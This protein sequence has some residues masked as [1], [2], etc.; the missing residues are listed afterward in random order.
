[1]TRRRFIADEVSEN[2]AVLT[3]GHA[4]HVARVLRVQVGQEFDISVGDAVRQ[5]TITSIRDDR[6]EFALGL[7][8]QV[9]KHAQ[10]T[11][12]LSIFKFDRME[13][14]IEKCTEIGVARIVPLVARRTDARLAAAAVKRRERWERIARQASEQSRRIAP[15]EISPPAKLEQLEASAGVLT[16][17]QGA[18]RI[19][20]G[21]SESH[22]MLRDV[23]ETHLASMQDGITLAIGPEGGWTSDERQCFQTSGWTQASLGNTILRSETAAVVASA[24]AMDGMR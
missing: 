8:Q 2:M 9:Q 21:E 1:M 24:I 7:E 18:L 20:L 4:F 6:V 16:A 3:G 11:L 13:W 12:V 5:G 22:T 10:L 14:A 17:A 19:V 15:P 23:V